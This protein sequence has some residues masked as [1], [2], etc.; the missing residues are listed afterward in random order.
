MD[1][2]QARPNPT[3]KPARK[4][5]RQKLDEAKALRL[6]QLGLGVNEIAQ[7]QGVHHSVISRF[8]KDNK[9]RGQVIATYRAQ[10]ADV[11]ADLGAHAVE[12]QHRIVQQ[13]D[14]EVLASLSPKDKTSLL[15]ALNAIGGTIYDKERLETGQSTANINLISRMMGAAL[16][17]AHQPTTDGGTGEAEA[18]AE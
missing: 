14:D 1:M 6:S 9:A 10:R 8:L 15:F 17:Q 11:F 13:V 16:Q 7:H 12:L 18:G 5:R 4:R 3:P 2:D